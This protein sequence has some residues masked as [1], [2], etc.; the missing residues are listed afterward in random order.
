[1]KS[2]LGASRHHRKEIRLRKGVR[3][4]LL[5]SQNGKCL[6]DTASGTAI[7]VEP[8]M[9]EA[10]YIIRGADGSNLATFAT[11]DEA[12]EKLTAFGMRADVIRM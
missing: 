12:V 5:L 6:Y 4:V 3:E 7:T 8:T 10:A 11:E 1:M 9:A 2:L